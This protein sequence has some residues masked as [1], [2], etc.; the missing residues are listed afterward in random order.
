MKNSFTFCLLL[1]FLIHFSACNSEQSQNT[2]QLETSDSLE[3]SLEVT[4]AIPVEEEVVDTVLAD[5]GE[6]IVEE[7]DTV[8]VRSF[9]LANNEMLNPPKS[10]EDYQPNERGIYDISWLTLTD[11]KFEEKISEVDSAL[12]LY[13]SFGKIVKSLNGK[14]VSIKGFI[15]PVDPT[16]HF[17]VLSA[18]PFS[19]CFF[20]GKAG[21]ESIMELELRAD[22]SRGYEMDQFSTF[23]GVFV[24]NGTD[25]EHCNYILK[26]AILVEEDE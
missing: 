21:P 9:S 26:D 3:D 18:N 16:E 10:I 14:K 24:L 25:V 8:A 22:P 12:Y 2:E 1:C 23:E 17:Y 5:E 11:V 7:E 4:A 19:A 13:P 15:I 6:E 20:C